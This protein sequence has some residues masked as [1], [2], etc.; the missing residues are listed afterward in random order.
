LRANKFRGLARARAS[1]VVGTLAKALVRR[2]HEVIVYATGDSRPAGT[3]RHCLPAAVW[4]PDDASELQHA[5]WAWNDL[6]R[7]DVDAVHLHSP[8]A[9]FAWDGLPPL[10]T[11]TIHHSRSEPLM[12]VYAR[13]PQARLV[14]VSRQQAESF[15]HLGELQ[16]FHHGLDV[17]D[18]PLGPGDGG[19]CV[20]LGR[21]APVKAP[22]LAIDAARRAAVPIVL[23][24]AASAR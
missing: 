10:P 24:C 20:F 23:R 6:R 22:H 11:V 18:Y 3:L 5:Q 13:R 15:A 8:A 4:P 12:S 7:Q 1:L 17:D 19:Y 14:A 9:L 21:I 16:V 2:G